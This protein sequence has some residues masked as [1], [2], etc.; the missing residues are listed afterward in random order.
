[1]PLGK[2]TQER[3][4]STGLLPKLPLYFFGLDEHHEAWPLPHFCSHSAQT[5]FGSCGSENT[6]A[7]L[8]IN[9]DNTNS[10]INIE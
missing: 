9:P 1:M 4:V 2:T 7:V 8:I 5:Q 3:V 10:V 6:V